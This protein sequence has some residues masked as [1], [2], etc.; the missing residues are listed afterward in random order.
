MS[1]LA[2]YAICMSFQIAVRLSKETLPRLDALVTAGAY[3]NRADAVRAAVDLLLDDA[4]RR[5]LDAAI[6]DGYRRIP[7]DTSDAWLDAT[8][9]AMVADEPW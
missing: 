8:T 1:A 7:D 5:R 9:K 6:V 2:W 4:E 3:P